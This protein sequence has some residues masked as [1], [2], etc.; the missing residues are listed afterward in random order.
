M[1]IVAGVVVAAVVLSQSTGSGTRASST[2]PSTAASTKP[3]K[4][5]GGAAVVV[6]PANVTVDVL[7]GTT[8]A[9]LAHKVNAKLVPPFRE[10]HAP[11]D[12]TDQTHTTTVVAYLPGHRA[13]ALAV[14]QRLGLHAASVQPIDQGTETVACAGATPCSIDVVVTVG[15]DLANL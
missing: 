9:G 14:A 15:S 2:S 7:N 5:N 4:H 6:N 10:A 8:I 1:L 11:G 12:A 3:A 13:A